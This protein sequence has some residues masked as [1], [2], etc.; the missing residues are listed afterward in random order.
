MKPIITIFLLNLFFVST[1]V[2]GQDFI[3]I[4]DSIVGLDSGAS[5]SVNWIDFDNDNDLD[6]FISNG[7]NTGQNNYLYRNDNGTFVKITGQAIV[8][9]NL[10]SDGASWGDYNNDGLPDLCVVNWYNKIKLLYLNTGNGTFSFQPDAVMSNDPSY[11]ETCSWGDYDNDGLLDL[12]VTN[13]AGSNHRNFLYRNTGNGDFQKMDTGVVISETGFSRGANW[14]DIDNDRDLDLFV[15]RESNNNNFLYRN[16]GAGV[17][18]KIT[19]TPLTSNGGE[20]WSSSWGD[21][22]NDGDLDVV[23]SNYGNQKNFLY[24]N[25]GNFTFTKITD[26]PVANE[27]G[28]NA[29]TGWG[30]YD[31]D[32]DLDLFISQAYVPPGF[33]QK[34]VN[35]LFKNMLIETGSAS[36]VKVTD[37]ILVN[38]SGYTYGFAWGDYDND[39]DL[40]IATANTFGENQRNGL[41]KNE[42]SNGNKWINIKCKGTVTNSSAIGTKVRVKANINGNDVW[43]MQEIDGQ[44][45]YCG[46]NLILHFGFG[47][48]AVIDSIKVEWQSGTDQ[49]FTNVPV[50]QNVNITENG[51]IISIYENNSIQKKTFNLYQNYP[52]PFNPETVIKYELANSGN[53]VRLKI[54]D[55]LGNEVRTLVDG[56]QREGS[57]EVSFNGNDLPSG[58]YYYKLETGI[59]FETKKM[60]LVK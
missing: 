12:F 24:R 21:Y 37:G 50:N 48:A 4:T 7:L 25:D 16:D 53:N 40:D 18:T 58:V 34:L 27:S 5:R 11:S 20:S 29:V 42:L 32:G 23:V 26:G 38:D 57:Y 44:S 49:V 3:K 1:L 39:G 2:M 22:D 59:F 45:G 9:D 36:F 17:F 19:N 47:N 51:T 28:Y 54:Y 33:T 14:V 60:F 56:V 8:Q 52:N 46:Q 15:C 30:D 6:L 55:A 10:P 41:Y 43:Q 35:K 13:S 31:N